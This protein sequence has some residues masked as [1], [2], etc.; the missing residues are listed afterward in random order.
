MLWLPLLLSCGL[1][2][3]DGVPTSAPEGAY[4][5]LQIDVLG[6]VHTASDVLV[7]RYPDCTWAQETYT[8]SE[9]HLRIDHA[10]LCPEA[11]HLK[12]Y[13]C[14]VGVIVPARWDAPTGA[15][16]VEETLT[17]K[18][19]FEAQQPNLPPKPMASCSITVEEGAYTMLRTYNGVWKWEMTT[20]S[21]LVHRLDYAP[22]DPDFATAMLAQTPE[23]R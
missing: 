16:V 13:G 1:L 9:G 20:P 21:G 5:S 6:T 7:G 2:P 19:G 12:G 22:D 14:E 4:L 11:G 15:L 10:V 17:A 18:A 8:F 3:T 23:A